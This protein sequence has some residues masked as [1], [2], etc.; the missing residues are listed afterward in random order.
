MEDGRYAM[1]ADVRI[2]GTSDMKA[3]A[4]S[5][6]VVVT[7]GLPR[8]PG[9]TREDLLQ[10]NAAI[11]E[12][13][14]RGIMEHAAGSIVIIVSNPLDVMTYLAYKLTGFSRQRVFGMG[15]NLD[16]SRFANLIAKKTFCGY[17]QCPGHGDRQSWRDDDAFGKVRH[18]EG[19]TL[20][21]IACGRRG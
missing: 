4:E 18:R 11:M 21:G 15:V 12:S 10:K 16:S 20:V 19:K 3:L 13:V 8:R 1:G 17:R 6:V 14:C 7:A 9:M 5:D 2:E